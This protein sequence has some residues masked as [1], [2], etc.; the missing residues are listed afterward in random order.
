[1]KKYIALAA[2]LAAGTA[3]ANA[4]K[5]Q[6][7]LKTDGS[8]EELGKLVADGNGIGAL[9]QSNGELVWDGAE[10]LTS[11]QLDFTLTVNRDSLANADLLDLTDG[12]GPRFAINSDGTFEWYNGGISSTNS[13]WKWSRSPTR[14][15]KSIF[16]FR[17]LQIMTRKGR[18]LGSGLCPLQQVKAPSFL[19]SSHPAMRP[20]LL[21]VMF[22]F[23]QIRRKS[24]TVVLRC[25]SLIITSSP[26]RRRS[27][28]SQVLE[29]WR[30]WLRVAAVVKTI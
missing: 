16:Q 29:L 17:M 7:T 10:T 23:G 12:N 18:A 5:T 3:F 20:R 21:R 6:V 1:M 9:T 19:W 2:L 30:S 14:I 24:I 27:V 28:C 8:N 22:E 26:S 15:T 4:E 25:I 11:W 13:E